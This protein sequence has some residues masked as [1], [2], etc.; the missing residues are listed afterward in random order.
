M[1][2]VCIKA[3]VT[4]IRSVFA[5][6]FKIDV[7]IGTPQI[8]SSPTASYDISGIIGMSGDVAGLV[9]I[10]FPV[11][12]AEKVVAALTGTQIKSDHPDFADAIGELANM[13][14]GGAK[15]LFGGTNAAIT[16]PSV[17]SGKDH[18]VRTPRDTPCIAIPCT[19]SCGEFMIEV[20][21]RFNKAVTIEPTAQA[22]A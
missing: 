2:P 9:V 19:T 11:A 4:S 6:M 16:C 10:S 14:S 8:K 21:I 13:V 20:A 22:A 12:T 18:V 7:Q 3:F 15:A 17:I 5:T 1:D